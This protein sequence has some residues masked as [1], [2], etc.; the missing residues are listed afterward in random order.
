MPRA[1]G[2]LVVHN[3]LVILKCRSLEGL[4]FLGC[5]NVS[6]FSGHP[7]SPVCIVGAE[8]PGVALRLILPACSHSSLQH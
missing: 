7:A 4:Q 8:M 5:C 2:M 3:S 6:D 1:S